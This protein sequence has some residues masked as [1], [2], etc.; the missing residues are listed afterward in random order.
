LTQGRLTV[1]YVL[2][3]ALEDLE[4][5]WPE[6]PPRRL[7][8]LWQATCFEAFLACPPAADYRELNLAPAGHWAC[9][10][11]SA[12]REGMRL[13]PALTGLDWKSHRVPGHFAIRFSLRIAELELGG[14][15]LRLGLSAILKRRDGA[16][17]FWALDHPAA[18][19]D[20][21]NPAGHLLELPV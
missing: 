6:E 13:E 5:P 21:H 4:L 19:P 16:R 3:G 10:R 14:P 20:F 18:A 7:D 17:E 2:D 12:P 9:Y 11:F 8:G 15:G 1:R